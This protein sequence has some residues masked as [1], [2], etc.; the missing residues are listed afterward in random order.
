MQYLVENY[1]VVAA[2][3][4]VSRGLRPETASFKS[5]FWQLDWWSSHVTLGKQSNCVREDGKETK[6]REKKKETRVLNLAKYTI[7]LTLWQVTNQVESTICVQRTSPSGRMGCRVRQ[8]L[9]SPRKVSLLFPV[10]HG[11]LMVQQGFRVFYWLGSS[12]PFS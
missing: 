1:K 4:S 8:T 9:P 12:M 11:K 6:K 5:M 2:W 3:F 10:L 7:T